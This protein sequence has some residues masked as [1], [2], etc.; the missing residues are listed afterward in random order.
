[1]AGSKG[2]TGKGATLLIGTGGTGETFTSIAQVKNPQLSGQTWSFDDITNLQSPAVGP[3][4]LEESIPNKM[5]PGKLDFD[6]VF[7]PG[8]AGQTAL[9]T[10]FATGALTD[11]KLQ[12]PCGPG[13]T[14]NGN[15]YTFS[16][17]VVDYPAPQISFDKTVT[18]K[19]SIKLNTTLG[20]TPGA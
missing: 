6:G 12:L 18:F 11:F 7:L 17:Y 9:G 4:V 5:S 13:Q 16:G 3:G 15:L 10:A 8:D 1:M 19:T 14:T 2:F 20:F